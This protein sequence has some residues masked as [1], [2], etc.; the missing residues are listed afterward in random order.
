[1]PTPFRSVGFWYDD[2]FRAAAR[3]VFVGQ[4]RMRQRHAEAGI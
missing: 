3:A 2:S 1:M 4:R